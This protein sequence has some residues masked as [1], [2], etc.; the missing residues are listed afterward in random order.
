MVD[1][2]LK[3][4]IHIKKDYNTYDDKPK[5]NGIFE[6]ICK[7]SFFFNTIKKTQTNKQNE[8]TW[9]TITFVIFPIVYQWEYKEKGIEK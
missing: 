5:Q 4:I 6:T 1:G 8:Q 7:S 2:K 3:I 9:K